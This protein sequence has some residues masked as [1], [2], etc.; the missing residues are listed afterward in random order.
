MKNALWL[1]L[2]VALG[3][4]AYSLTAVFVNGFNW[5]LLYPL[6]LGIINLVAFFMLKEK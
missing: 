5:H 1:V 2:A 6:L 3:L 4:F